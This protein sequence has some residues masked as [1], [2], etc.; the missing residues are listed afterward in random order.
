[1]S[2]STTTQSVYDRERHVQNLKDWFG[3][4]L[5]LTKSG[6]PRKVFCDS[7]MCATLLDGTRQRAKQ[8]FNAFTLYLPWSVRNMRH[9]WN[10]Y[11]TIAPPLY[12]IQ[13]VTRTNGYGLQPPIWTPKIWLN[14]LFLRRSVLPAYGSEDQLDSL[15][16]DVDVEIDGE[17]PDLFVLT[18]SDRIRILR[19]WVEA[20]DHLGAAVGS[21]ITADW[22]LSGSRGFWLQV[23][24]EDAGSRA[25][26]LRLRVERSKP[27]VQF[28][29]STYNV[30]LGNLGNTVCRLPWSLHQRTDN[31]SVHIDPLTGQPEPLRFVHATWNSMTLEDCAACLPR[32]AS[33]HPLTV[34]VPCDTD[35]LDPFLDDST[36]EVLDQE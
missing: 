18:D 9:R 12:C 6:K 24:F 27:I 19:P 7:R 13:T 4:D 34:S 11:G 30:D 31:V 2:A 35:E 25:D 26:A 5:W 17:S 3:E 10:N 33:E 28:G 15:M 29:D 32:G 14:H 22:M 16:M 36:N 23:H 21:P 20:M 8:A 1:M